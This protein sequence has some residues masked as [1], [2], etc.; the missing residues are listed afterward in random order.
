MNTSAA[1]VTVEK[2]T[3]NPITYD[4]LYQVQLFSG[5]LN[6]FRPL[7]FLTDCGN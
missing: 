6:K 7:I 3:Y 5:V 1:Y 2:L 4:F